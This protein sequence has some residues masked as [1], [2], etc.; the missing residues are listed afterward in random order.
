M[1]GA[2]AHDSKARARAPI[3]VLSRKDMVARRDAL[4]SKEDRPKRAK[5]R[6]RGWMSRKRFTA[7]P[8]VVGR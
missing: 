4:P 3:L 6:V 7:E 8:S 1:D 2:I 5:V